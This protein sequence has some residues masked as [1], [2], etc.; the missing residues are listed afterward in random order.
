MYNVIVVAKLTYG[1]EVLPMNETLY[2][3]LDAF[4][5]RGMRK[6]LNMKSTYI[7]RSSENKNEVVLEKVLEQVNKPAAGESAAMRPK[8]TWKEVL[9]SGRIQGKAVRLF[10]NI[11][12]SS[13]RNLLRKVTLE[14]G[15]EDFALPKKLRVGRPRVNWIIE[16]AKL[17]WK[18]W[19]G[20]SEAEGQERGGAVEEFDYEN[21]EMVKHLLNLAKA[22]GGT[23]AQQTAIPVSPRN[24]HT[25]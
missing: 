10:E 13:D 23:T 12:S 21:K 24:A 2:K 3:K 17:A 6:I 9:P 1:L 20:H 18:E 4:Y 25:R 11:T 7:E 8:K 16:T 5:Y 19:K 22:R 14:E 15:E